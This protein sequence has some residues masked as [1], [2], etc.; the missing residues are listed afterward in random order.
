MHKIGIGIFVLLFNLNGL[1]QKKIKSDSTIFK[2]Q[3][4]YLSDY[5]YNGRAD[6]IQY[7]YQTT[8]A[9]VLLA[10]GFYGDFSANYLLTPGDKRFD[11]FQLDLGYEFNVGEKLTGSIYGSKYFYSAESALL[12]G[13]IKT[14]IGGSLEYDFGF[15]QFSNTLD[16]F[17]ASKAD[18]QLLTGIEKSILFNNKQGSWNIIPSLYA[19]LS[20]INYYE[21]E[22]VRR[23]NPRNLTNRPAGEG[24]VS[25]STKTN[26]TGFKFLAM[27][28]SLPLYFEGGKWGFYVLP[29]YAI[30]FNQITSTT[31]ITNT[32]TNKVLNSFNSTA[33]SELNLSGKWYFQTGIFFKF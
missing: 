7:P 21:S 25:V 16:V 30:P 33:Y 10:N 26:Q 32:L 20:T 9:S 27:E 29:T 12:N 5:I 17:F 2:I 19:T 23:I 18:V 8:T 11:F 22:L 14:D 31:T 28:A 24:T 6:S 4:D 15:L 1:S 13:N 3:V